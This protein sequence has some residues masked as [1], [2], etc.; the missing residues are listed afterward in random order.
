VGVPEK[1]KQNKP[2]KVKFCNT[3]HVGYNSL[4]K[5]LLGTSAMIAY[6]QQHTTYRIYS[7]VGSTK[8]CSKLM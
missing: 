3:L 1:Q 7:I 5:V 6:L 4:A 2:F 8:Y